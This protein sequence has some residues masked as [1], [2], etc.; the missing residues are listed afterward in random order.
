M[1][2]DEGGIKNAFNVYNKYTSIFLACEKHENSQSWIQKISELKTLVYNQ[3][4]Q[5]P[6]TTG[7]AIKKMIKFI[8]QSLSLSLFENGS[9]CQ[10]MCLQ[11]KNLSLNY[12]Q[13]T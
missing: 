10:Y 12:E 9:Q 5:A 11:N 6:P 3:A 7:Y 8:V 4:E 2:E 13:D 1:S